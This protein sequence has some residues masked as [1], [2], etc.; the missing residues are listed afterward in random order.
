MEKGELPLDALK[1]ELLEETGWT[2]TGL[3]MLGCMHLHHLAPKAENY[4]YPHPDFLW[5]IYIA[6]AEDFTS[7]TIIPDDYALSSSFRPIEE[8]RKLPLQ[9]GS[10]MLLDTA[11]KLR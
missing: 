8:V 7:K 11:L 1:R 9:K 4:A 2:L 6:D 3:R 5:P 10:L